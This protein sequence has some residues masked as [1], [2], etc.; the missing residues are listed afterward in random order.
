MPSPINYQD[1]LA[2]RE[3]IRP[4][5]TPTPLRHYPLLDAAIGHGIRVLVKHENHHPTQSFKIRNGLS[6]ILG[7]SD[8]ERARGVIGASTGNHGLG[9]A[10]AG[11]LTGTKVTICVPEGNNPGKNAAI[12]ALGAELLEIGASYDQTILGCARVREERGLTLVHSTNNAHVIA[13]AGTM[14][15]ELLEQDPAL[16]AVIIALGGGSQAVGAITVARELKPSLGVYA[17]GAASA[18]AQFESW[19]R[20]ERLSGLPVATF[21]EGIATGSAYE[22]TFD[23]LKEGLAGF[24]TV[25]EEA[26]YQAVRELINLTHNIPE[27]AGA[28]GFAGLKLL[29]P[30]LAGKRVAIIMCGG[31]L[32]ERD[33]KKALAD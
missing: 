28:A 30:Q 7:L 15:M 6:A 16:D 33:L 13:G 19:Q 9:L 27:G 5:L 8:A 10:Y 24:V 23:A 22:M 21:A 25:S 1:V 11:G 32:A 4:H 18:S 31:N 17:V 14:T 12:R 26:M 2:A 3:R 20:G 29:A